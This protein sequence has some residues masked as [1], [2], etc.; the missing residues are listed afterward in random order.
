MMEPDNP[1][2]LYVREFSESLHFPTVRTFADPNDCKAAMLKEAKAVA[3]E[4]D[5]VLNDDMS[6][7]DVEI[8]PD[9]IPNQLYVECPNTGALDCFKFFEN[10]TE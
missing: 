1:I 7:T 10:E 8:D 6:E 5:C 2:Y 4:N 3:M 9:D